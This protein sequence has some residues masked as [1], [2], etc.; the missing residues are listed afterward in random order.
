MRHQQVHPLARV[1]L[2]SFGEKFRPGALIHQHQV[3]RGHASRLGRLQLN[4]STRAMINSI[5]EPL[6][7]LQ[8]SLH[9]LL[10]DQEI[11]VP[12]K[13]RHLIENHCMSADEEAGQLFPLRTLY[14]FD[15]GVHLSDAADER[16]AFRPSGL[17]HGGLIVRKR[18][19]CFIRILSLHL[20]A[21][22]ES[23]AGRLAGLIVGFENEK[24]QTHGV[25]LI[26]V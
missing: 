24:G 1:A 16:D 22:E 23:V 17:I 19:R 4:E 10:R 15:D 7:K 18:P 20:S 3:H 25:S 11:D 9:C 12:R 6:Q 14:D 8:P 26:E 5:A 13:T 21:I 2:L